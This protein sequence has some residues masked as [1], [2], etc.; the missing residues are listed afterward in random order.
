MMCSLAKSVGLACVVCNQ[1]V[2]GFWRGIYSS[3]IGYIC[4]RCAKRLEH[5]RL[6]NLNTSISFVP[7]RRL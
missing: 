4:D 6:G 5:E 2:L 1:W 3:E 7:S